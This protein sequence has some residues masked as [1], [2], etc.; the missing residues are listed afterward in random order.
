VPVHWTFLVPKKSGQKYQNPPKL[1]NRERDKEREI[2]RQTEREVVRY[3]RP[4]EEY[5]SFVQ[6]VTQGLSSTPQPAC[7]QRHFRIHVTSSVV[8]AIVRHR[9]EEHIEEKVKIEGAGEMGDYISVGG[10]VSLLEW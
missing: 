4:S 2:D 9:T 8:A 1:E 7:S 3:I 10:T 5:S 6:D